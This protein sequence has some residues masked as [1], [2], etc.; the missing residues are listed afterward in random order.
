MAAQVLEAAT[1]GGFDLST[2]PQTPC[3][4]CAAP[5]AAEDLVAPTCNTRRHAACRKCMAMALAQ[6][7]RNV[8]GGG[9]PAN[10]SAACACL[11]SKALFDSEVVYVADFAH[12]YEVARLE[13]SV[14]RAVSPHASFAKFIP[15]RVLVGT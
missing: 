5:R 14:L 8:G 6:R 13:R 15:T 11:V 4:I 1:D 7:W 2:G 10:V 9:S 12:S 3:A